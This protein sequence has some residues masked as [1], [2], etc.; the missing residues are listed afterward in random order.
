MAQIK[1]N[2]SNVYS[3]FI[4]V[5]KKNEMITLRILERR[6]SL[7]RHTLGFTYGTKK[8]LHLC[9]KFHL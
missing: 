8:N 4:C 9:R 5:K 6:Q 3:Q 7:E 2:E 1:S